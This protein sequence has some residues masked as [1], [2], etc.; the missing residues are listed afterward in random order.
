[1]SRTSKSPFSISPVPALPGSRKIYLQGSTPDILVPMR[2]ISQH[3]TKGVHT[4]TLN[5]PVPVYD[6]SGPYTADGY[7]PD[8]Q[9]GL[10]RIRAAWV[11]S[12]Q[13]TEAYQG[14]PLQPSDD[15]YK[16]DSFPER[17]SCRYALVRVV[18]SRSFDM[19][20]MGL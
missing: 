11:Q 12:R 7:N 15:N 3:P 5:P 16:H 6:T 9:K 14:R 18:S 4:E 20:G 17:N 19:R 2:E 1:M 10:P 13:D 8:I